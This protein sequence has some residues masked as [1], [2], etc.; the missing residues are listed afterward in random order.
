ME[1]K[2]PRSKV[3]KVA[4]IVGAIAGIVAAVADGTG[5]IDTGAIQT[6]LQTIGSLI[7]G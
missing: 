7:S 5:A 3:A 2:K 6:I 4:V 1:A